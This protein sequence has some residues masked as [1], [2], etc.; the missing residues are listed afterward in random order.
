[1]SIFQSAVKKLT[2]SYVGALL[3]VCLVFSAPIYAVASSRLE[4][5]AR[6]QA[7]IVARLDG[8]FVTQVLPQVAIIRDQQI[9]QD[10]QQLLRSIIVANLFILAV[11]TYWSYWFAKRTLKPIEE[12][13]DAQARFTT[14]ASHELRT[15]LAIMQTEIEV[16]LRNQ[17]FTPSLA[18]KV[19]RS[20]L[21][22]IARLRTLS[23]QLLKLTRLDN[24]RIQK[25]PLAFSKLVQEEIKRIEKQHRV[26][27]HADIAK[28]LHLA[29]DEHLLRQLI[30]ILAENAIKYAGGKPP[31]IH[32]SLK[33]QDDTLQLTITDHGLGIKASEL[34]YIF[35]RFY[36]GSNAAKHATGHGLGLSLARQITEAH[37]GTLTAI[38][39][40]GKTTSFTATLPSA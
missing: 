18:K 16:A 36:R 38:S 11:G 4:H 7:D 3:A 27:I 14:D 33:K 1:M 29:G 34:P 13:H 22:E 8:P 24:A 9:H 31:E 10:R 19:L 20:N 40:P 12:A 37:A 39:T 23:E 21:E 30:A 32:L 17:T 6:K 25:A 2:L 35:D 15:P 28:N 5:G 26:T